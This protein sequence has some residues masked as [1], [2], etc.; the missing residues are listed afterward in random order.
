MNRQEELKNLK[1]EYYNL[2][3][4]FTPEGIKNKPIFDLSNTEEI[5]L[6]ITKDL[7]EKWKLEEWLVN[8]KREAEVS[9]AGIRGPQNILYPWDTRFPLNQLGVVLAT[10]AK[11][12]VLKE[13]IKDRQIHKI[14]SGEVRYN[15]K[16]YVELISRI[17]AALGIHTH[18]PFN[19][20]TIPVWMVSFL[21]FM[22]DYDG[23]EYV[24]SSHAISSK[25]ATKDL[26][27]QGSQ[28]MPQNQQNRES[29]PYNNVVRMP[30]A[31]LVSGVKSA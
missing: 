1:Q 25:I 2:A 3:E 14:A 24:T 9:T 22:L 5:E 8:Y 10:L 12:L 16:S 26:D 28:F 19:R 17:Q 27:S 4:K 31:I 13:E 30:C 18:L 20:E 11:T 7:V 29:L 23:G 15:T 21:I 6:T